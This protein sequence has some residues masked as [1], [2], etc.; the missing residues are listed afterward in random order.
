MSY[1]YDRDEKHRLRDEVGRKA[2]PGG[3]YGPALMSTVRLHAT[4]LYGRSPDERGTVVGIDLKTN[5]ALVVWAGKP[6]V[7]ARYQYS[8]LV[9]VAS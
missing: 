5:A 3:H 8:W 1:D 6:G 7:I 4:R 9:E 2:Q